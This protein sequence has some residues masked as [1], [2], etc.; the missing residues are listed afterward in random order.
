MKFS[1]DGIFY[2]AERMERV[3]DENAPENTLRY[4]FTAT[5]DPQS[6][7]GSIDGRRI[8]LK[9]GNLYHLGEWNEKPFRENL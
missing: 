6:N 8:R 4:I 1:G 2:D 7:G 5:F 3:E 9:F